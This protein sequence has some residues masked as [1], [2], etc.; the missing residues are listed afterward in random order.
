M[1]VDSLKQ[2]WMRLMSV[3]R[4]VISNF[5]SQN[6]EKNMTFGLSD[7][8]NLY[9]F[10]GKQF[11][12]KPSTIQQLNLALIYNRSNERYEQVK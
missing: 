12:C 1:N 9:E 7:E 4:L 6:T 8:E 3:L 11:H 5:S 2:L 10:R